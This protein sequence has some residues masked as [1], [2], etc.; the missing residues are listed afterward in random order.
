MTQRGY[1]GGAYLGCDTSTGLGFPDWDLLLRAYGIPVLELGAEGLDT[2]GFDAMFA[3]PDPACF[4]VP[5]DPEQTYYPKITSR[6]TES[7]SMESNPL[8]LMSPDLPDDVARRV[9]THLPLDKK[10]FAR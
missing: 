4:V 10:E 7:G 6:V 2:A 8:H 5:I 1:F 9:F 3:A